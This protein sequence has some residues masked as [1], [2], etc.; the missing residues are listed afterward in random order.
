MSSATSLNSDS[1][2]MMFQTNTPIS[3]TSQQTVTT[4]L[5]PV[6]PSVIKTANTDLPKQIS[7]EENQSKPSSEYKST[8][9]INEKSLEETEALIAQKVREECINLEADL[10]SVLYK[11]RTLKVDVGSDAEATD[12]VQKTIALLEFFNDV[13]ET[14]AAQ[15]G[16]VS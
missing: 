6:H 2:T 9:L 15:A 1:K 14:S 11:S 12:M 7:N 16:E 3:G 10:K 4:N 13:T 8:V 5:Q